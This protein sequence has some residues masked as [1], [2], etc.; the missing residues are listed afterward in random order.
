MPDD[1][2]TEAARTVTHYL[3]AEAHARSAARLLEWLAVTESRPEYEAVASVV[4]AL[5]NRLRANRLE[6]GRW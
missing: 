2:S 1:T 6:A 5:A 3:E 4:F